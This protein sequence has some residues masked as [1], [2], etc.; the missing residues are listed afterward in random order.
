MQVISKRTLDATANDKRYMAIA[1]DL[2]A[3]YRVA[4][5]AKWEKLLD[6]QQPYPKAEAV[7][8][9]NDV[10]TVFNI[11][12]NEFRLVV[13]IIYASKKIFVKHVITHAEY[14][15]DEWKRSLKKEQDERRR[16]AKASGRRHI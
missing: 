14:D 4:K 10:Y 16:G 6:V 7:P 13:K 11:R 12:H 15:R 3:W 1:K 8:V 9:G 5:S 2:A